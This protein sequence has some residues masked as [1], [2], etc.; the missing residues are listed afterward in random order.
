MGRRILDAKLLA[1]P[2]QRNTQ[3]EKDAIKAAKKA[4]EIWRNESARVAQKGYLCP[5][6]A[7]VRQGQANP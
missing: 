4:A 6:D 1:A 5:Q 7:Q 2:K 3:A